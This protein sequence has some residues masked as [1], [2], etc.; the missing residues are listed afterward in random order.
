LS[1]EEQ[2]YSTTR[3]YSDRALPELGAT[4]TI[5]G[6]RWRV[7]GQKTRGNQRIMAEKIPEGGRYLLPLESFEH[8]FPSKKEPQT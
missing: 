3:R 6:Q 8:N 2:N 4:V 7:T 5:R 1:P